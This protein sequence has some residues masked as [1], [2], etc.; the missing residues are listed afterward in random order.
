MALHNQEIVTRFLLPLNSK[1]FQ[2]KTGSRV[3][4]GCNGNFIT[5]TQKILVE[6]ING[7]KL[8]KN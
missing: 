2:I 1:Y 4:S 5:S 8:R 3:T 6:M 7:R